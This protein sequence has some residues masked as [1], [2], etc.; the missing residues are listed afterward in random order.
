MPFAYADGYK[1]AYAVS[2]SGAPVVLHPGMFEDGGHWAHLGYTEVLAE[3]HTVIAVDP[4]G[5]GASDAPRD[6]A[7]YALER[8][9]ASVVAV[10]DDLGLDRAAFWGYSLGALTGYA[11]AACAP[12]RLTR[13]V[14]GAYDPYGFMARV[15]AVLAALG[16]PADHDPYELVRGGAL[17]S[18]YQV[19]VI[20]AGDPAAHRANYEAFSR[21]PG[22]AD[23]LAASGVP[24]L[25]YA[26]TADPWH[27]PMRDYARSH[28]AEFFSVADADHAT[29]PRRPSEV[30]PHVLGFLA[31]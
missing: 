19:G 10:F 7:A 1:I 25:M 13:L 21:E 9:A 30:L 6:P 16:L 11:V 29:T 3:T 24:T 22:L 23:R 8:R 14:A 18:A 5:L 2:G 20:E 28:G 12:E 31:R 17:E 26:G 27:D 4:L 15:P